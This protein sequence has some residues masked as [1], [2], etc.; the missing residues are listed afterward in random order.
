MGRGLLFVLLILL[1][2]GVCSGQDFSEIAESFSLQLDFSPGNV[3]G[4]LFVDVYIV[5]GSDLNIIE[6]A[7]LDSLISDSFSMQSRAVFVSEGNET[8]MRE[9]EIRKRL[10]SDNETS[11]GDLGE[12]TNI[13]VLVGG[14]NRNRITEGVYAAGF[15][16]NESTRF[17][18][19]LIVGTGS[20]DSDSRVIVLYH[21]AVGEGERL[22]REAV[23]YSPLR[24]FVPDAYVPV[25]ATGIG[26]LL[27]NLFNITKTV[28]EFLALD[29]GRK[30]KVFEHA[31]PSFRGIR[32]REVS[33]LLGAAFV[34]GFAVTWTFVGPKTEFF[35]FLFLNSGICLFAALSHEISHRLT[36]KLFGIKV[37][38]KFW[39]MGSFITIVTAFLGNAFGVQGFLM[40]KLEGDVSRWKYAV[41]KLVAPVISTTIT[42]IFAFLYLHD[43]GVIL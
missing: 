33:A 34:L 26:M 10:L 24:G 43:P 20:L 42:V 28:A 9:V 38:Y 32:L 16:V 13:V 15:I 41:T 40:E 30:K 23:K 2:N 37:T 12:G 8:V 6:R 17:M 1:F 29:I 25:V 22:E 19:Q 18:G 35:S 21:R 3:S 39:Y 27:M 36:G 11:P 5:Y 7:V 4:D 31:G 14:R